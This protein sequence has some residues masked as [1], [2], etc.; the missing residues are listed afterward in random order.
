MRG[1]ADAKAGRVAAGPDLA[2]HLAIAD[3]L[4]D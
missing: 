2:A 4:Q 1:L 3:R